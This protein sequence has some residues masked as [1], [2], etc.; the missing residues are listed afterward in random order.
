MTACAVPAKKGTS[1]LNTYLGNLIQLRS[2]HQTILGYER[3][4]RS[5]WDETIMILSGEVV[6]TI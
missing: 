6:L 5:E 4:P 3:L 1:P 2:E